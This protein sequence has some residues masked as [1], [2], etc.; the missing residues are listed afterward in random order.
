MKDLMRLDSLP[1]P[2]GVHAGDYD[3]GN[4]R[5]SSGWGALHRAASRGQ[6]EACKYLLNAAYH[7]IKSGT[8]ANRVLNI[9]PPNFKPHWIHMRT[10]FGIRQKEIKIG[11]PKSVSLHFLLSCFISCR[12]C[13]YPHAVNSS[14]SSRSSSGVSS[15]QTV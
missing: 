4:S 3:L 13:Y 8:G 11:D 1:P 2:P 10:A 15:G 7:P 6:T 14:R 12:C 9:R 5:N